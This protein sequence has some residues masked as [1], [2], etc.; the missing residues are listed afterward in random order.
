MSNGLHVSA[1]VF[2]VVSTKRSALHMKCIQQMFLND[3]QEDAG[4]ESP[5][6]F[7]IN[8]YLGWKH[9]KEIPFIQK[10]DA[11]TN[12]WESKVTHLIH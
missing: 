10:Q 1:H 4:V 3:E 11:E 2:T 9:E 8:L 6:I 5:G 7:L 12:D